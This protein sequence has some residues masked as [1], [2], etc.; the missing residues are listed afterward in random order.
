MK[1]QCQWQTRIGH[2]ATQLILFGLL[3][4]LVITVFA[5]RHTTWRWHGEFAGLPL[6]LP[7]ADILHFATTP[8]G[9]RLL[10]ERSFTTRYGIVD[11]HWQDSE[12]QLHLRCAPCRVEAPG[13]ADRA[14]EI[15]SIAINARRF[16]NVLWGQI[17]VDGLLIYWSAVLGDDDLSLTATFA[18][19]PLAKL[20]ALLGTAIPENAIAQIDGDVG[21]QFDLQ[22]PSGDSH[23]SVKTHGLRVAGLGTERLRG[24]IAPATHTGQANDV[25]NIHQHK[26]K[27]TT[28]AGR[29]YLRRAIIA[30]EDQHF[31]EHAGYDI[32]AIT[33]SFATNVNQRRIQ[34]GASTLTQ[35]LAKML[36][37]GDERSYIRKLREL[38]YAVEMERTLGKAQILDLYLATAPW[39]KNLVGAD[40]AARY[41]FGKS[42]EDLTIAEA[43]WL[44][45]MLRNPERALK[46]PET[47]NQRSRWIISSLRGI[48]ARQR[49]VA[50]CELKKVSTTITAGNKR[51][52][53]N[54]NSTPLRSHKFAL[55]E[56]SQQPSRNAGAE[57]YG[58]QLSSNACRI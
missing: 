52:T 10:D 45:A 56:H 43:A 58:F 32:Q 27:A 48:R 31:F 23:V 2:L 26:A 6:S 53:Q 44:A 37:V 9:G 35:Q 38:L 17:D 1:T 36:F 21:A 28:G 4:L 34:F 7:V 3:L 55:I 54:A 14:I 41:Y 47:Q 25:G 15:K 13:L 22:L 5:F 30:A 11:I 24:V 29:R 51:N 19:T 39:G 40:A 20:Y 50:L 18:A 8:L 46:E 57:S 16:G 49:V 42:S 12:R 33:A